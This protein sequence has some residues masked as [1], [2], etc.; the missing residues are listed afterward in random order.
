[1][2]NIILCLMAK[3]VSEKSSINTCFFDFSY[4]VSGLFGKLPLR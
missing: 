3:S 4:R 2:G 1:M